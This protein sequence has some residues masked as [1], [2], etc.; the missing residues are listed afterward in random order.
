M[1]TLKNLQKQTGLRHDSSFKSKLPDLTWIRHESV[2]NVVPKVWC[3]YCRRKPAILC[4]FNQEAG[5]KHDIDAYVDGTS[6]I[7][8]T[9]CERHAQ[10]K[11]MNRQKVITHFVYHSD[12]FF[13]R[14]CDQRPACSTYLFIYVYSP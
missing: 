14:I 4:Q 5:L 13:Q 2:G 1:T 9:N 7:K 6:N 10:S 3:Y 8:M 11:H 12:I